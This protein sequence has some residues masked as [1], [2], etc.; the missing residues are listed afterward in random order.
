LTKI[1]KA[2]KT[3]LEPNNKQR[4]FFDRCSGASRYVYN[5]GLAEWK[6]Q[7]EAG[8]KP[9]A[10]SLR[11]QFN[12]QKDEVC[13][14]IRELPYAVTESAFAN[15]GTAFDNF[16]QRVKNGEAKAGYPKFKKRGEKSTF[17]VRNT[18]IESNRVRMTSA[19]WI[20]LKEQG[21]IPVDASRYGIYATISGSAGR[22]FISV[23]VETEIEEL[24]SPKTEPIGIDVGIKSLA[25]ASNGTFYANPKALSVSERKLKHLQRELARRKKGGSNWRK[26][27]VKLSRCYQRISNVRA[28]NLHNISRDV[29][30][31]NPAAIVIENLNVKG[32]VQNHHLAQAI[33]DASFAELRRQLEYKARWQGIDVFVAD[34]W[35]ASSKTCSR[36][37]AK[38]DDLTLADRIFKCKNCGFIIDRDLNAAM[39]LAALAKGET[40]PDCLGS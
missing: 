11:K 31:K 26:T 20:R 18:K 28:N 25:V 27:K 14:W 8:E 38:D 37:G 4:S 19:G 23:L 24:I 39:N 32:M 21:Y 29:V 30:D 15:L 34:R 2:F 9:S 7:Y 35:F 22:W 36:C 5:W 16:F 6:R 12:T 1:N 40:H 13:P 3:E 33:S 17:Q 10:Y